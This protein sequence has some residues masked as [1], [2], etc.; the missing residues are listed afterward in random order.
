MTK[1]HSKITK[2]V[3][4]IKNENNNNKKIQLLIK[5]II[6]PLIPNLYRIK[7]KK[8][9]EKKTPVIFNVFK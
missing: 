5:T 1:T 9:E 7:K 8:E 6:I 4:K 2:N 3:S